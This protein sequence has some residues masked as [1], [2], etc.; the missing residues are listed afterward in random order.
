MPTNVLKL[1]PADNMVVALADLKRGQTVRLGSNALGLVSNVPAKH[2]F[3]AVDLAVGDP[4]CMHGVLVGEAIVP[5]GRGN[6]RDGN[7]PLSGRIPGCFLWFRD[8]GGGPNVA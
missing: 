8:L 5:I 2:Q 6:T 7:D 4:V 1:D 3:S